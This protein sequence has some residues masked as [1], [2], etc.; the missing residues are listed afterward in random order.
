L[1]VPLTAEVG[2]E[3]AG[4]EPA[5]ANTILEWSQHRFV[6]GMRLVVE[7]AFLP[8]ERE[9]EGLDLRVHEV[10]NPVELLLELRFDREVDGHDET[11]CVGSPPRA[12]PAAD[13]NLAFV[14]TIDLTGGCD[15]GAE[16]VTIGGV[17]MHA[18]GHEALVRVALAA[19]HDERSGT[20]AVEGLGNRR[21]QQL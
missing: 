6:H 18:N 13:G 1:A 19:Q 5:C 14:C 2:A 8:T 11:S 10:A 7:S 21:V 17:R 4:P 15:D 16:L 20:R 3:V 12:R 9:V